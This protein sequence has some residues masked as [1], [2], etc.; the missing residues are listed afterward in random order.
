MQLHPESTNV[1]YV[2]LIRGLRVSWICLRLSEPDAMFDVALYTMVSSIN[3]FS[4]W[5]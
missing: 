2:H 4:H 1:L 5:N 3:L